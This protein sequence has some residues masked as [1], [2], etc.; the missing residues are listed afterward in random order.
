M[1]EAR[2]PL[3]GERYGGVRSFRHSSVNWQKCGVLTLHL[4]TRMKCVSS[5]RRG[6][7]LTKA[8]LHSVWGKH[9]S[10]F[11]VL[12]SLVSYA[13]IYHNRTCSKFTSW[14]T[15][16]EPG[17]PEYYTKQRYTQGAKCW[18]GPQRSLE[19]CVMIPHPFTLV[20]A[21]ARM[22]N[23]SFSSVAPKMRCI[24]CRSPRSVNT[25]LLVRLLRC[26]SL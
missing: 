12:R 21:N 24:P 19:V 11:P 1:E 2:W 5:T 26:A 14:N 16:A 17:T 3:F 22:T 23:S 6:R 18:N 15:L 13:Y 25:R 9:L 10:C 8:V 4:G 7:S 20:R